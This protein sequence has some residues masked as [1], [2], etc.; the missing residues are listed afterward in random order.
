[1]DGLIGMNPWEKLKPF[2]K[3]G[4]IIEEALGKAARE[5]KKIAFRGKLETVRRK[6]RLR[7]IIV[8]RILVRNLR[9][10]YKIVNA[11]SRANDFYKDLIKIYY[12]EEDLFRMRRELKSMLLTADKLR[13]NYIEKLSSASTIDEMGR[14]R[15]ECLG[16]LVSIVKRKRELLNK[17]LELWKYA[18]RLP[19][20][21]LD[22]PTIVVAGPPNVGKSTLVNALSS[23]EVKVASY[24][25]TTKDI[26]VGHIPTEFYRIQIIDT[27]GL[28]DRPLSQRNEIELKAIIAL[29]YL[30]DIIVF[31]FDPSPLRYYNLEEQLSIYNEVRKSFKDA[32]I[33]PVVNKIDIKEID[34]RDVLDDANMFEISLKDG[35]GLEALKNRLMDLAES[36]F[37]CKVR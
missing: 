14:I 25:F 33:V 22:E 27:P 19:S 13:N 1:M 35:V 15:R 3:P 30:S 12:S 37:K 20:V 31:M 2:S 17:V 26:H 8:Y 29:S 16:R 18:H 11:Y 6:E 21:N 32:Y 4:V 28:L 5:S 9:R 7:I 34:F 24:P 23:A 36:I 10:A